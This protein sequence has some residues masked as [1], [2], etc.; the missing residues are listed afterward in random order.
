MNNNWNFQGK[1]TEK[2]KR[3]GKDWRIKEKF[4]YLHRQI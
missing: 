2:E 4:V 1:A 3:E